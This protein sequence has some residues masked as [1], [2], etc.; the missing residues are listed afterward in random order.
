MKS[1]NILKGVLYFISVLWSAWL[2]FKSKNLVDGYITV[3]ILLSSMV[4]NDLLTK[5]IMMR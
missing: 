3:I 4:V 2:I 1:L 5:H